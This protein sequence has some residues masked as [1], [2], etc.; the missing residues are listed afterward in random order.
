M[1]SVS[2]TRLI[3]PIIMYAEKKIGTTGKDFIICVPATAIVKSTTSFV[4]N[5]KPL[6]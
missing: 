2:I 3:P 5:S 6:K 1:M 4:K